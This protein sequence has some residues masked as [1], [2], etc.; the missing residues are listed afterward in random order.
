MVY[1]VVY[2]I[3][4]TSY[5][6][7][8]IG[9]SSTRSKFRFR[10][11]H[12]WQQADNGTRISTRGGSGQALFAELQQQIAMDRRQRT[13]QP[14]EHS[15]QDLEQH[16][17]VDDHMS[18]V[19]VRRRK[20]LPAAPDHA[21][22]QIELSRSKT[23]VSGDADI[24]RVA[25]ERDDKPAESSFRRNANDKGVRPRSNEIGEL[26]GG[27]GKCKVHSVRRPISEISGADFSASECVPLDADVVVRYNSTVSESLLVCPYPDADD[28]HLSKPLRVHHVWEPH[29]VDV[30]LA[31]IRWLVAAADGRLREDRDSSS[32][33][34]AA[35]GVFD[36]GANV[37][38][39]SL[40]AAGM[41]GCR[42]VA[43]EP[44]RP[45]IY[46]LHKAVEVNKL[47]KQ[48]RVS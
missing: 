39:Y 9:A 41:F 25:R 1:S 11:R 31:S 44:Y 45:N 18:R 32:S 26:R 17:V 19:A 30:F 48:V 8:I 14:V 46:R 47:T 35:I 5:D 13:Q 28:V 27:P 16:H 6:A 22:E 37:G 38:Q 40:L 43:V 23:V 33:F 10:S 3:G 15:T 4:K 12:E 2:L 7:T 20:Q 36:I 42:V 21:S 29:V 24:S 34:E